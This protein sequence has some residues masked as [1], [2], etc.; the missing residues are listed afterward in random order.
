MSNASSR[1]RTSKQIMKLSRH[2]MSIAVQ[3]L[4]GHK[5]LLH[6]E[7]KMVSGDDR[8]R[9]LNLRC[10]LCNGEEETTERMIFHCDAL[11]VK[12]YD[13]L[14]KYFQDPRKDKLYLQEVISFIK[15]AYLTSQN[16]PVGHLTNL[17]STFI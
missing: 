4:S 8:K 13:C 16:I 12:R 14:G 1:N 15:S 7:N 17:N 10:W 6:H 9:F 2:D 3:Y 5:F 11:A